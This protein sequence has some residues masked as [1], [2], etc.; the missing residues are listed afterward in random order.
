MFVLKWGLF[1]KE[2]FFSLNLYFKNAFFSKMSF[3]KFLHNFFFFFNN[4]KIKS[5]YIKKKKKFFF[6][7]KTV[8]PIFFFFKKGYF[9]KKFSLTTLEFLL[10]K[11]S[12]EWAKFVKEIFLFLKIMRFFLEPKLSL[13][14]AMNIFSKSFF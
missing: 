8:K 9:Q 6:S 10:K 13:K 1:Q 11:K 3:I 5:F 7:I 4:P 12:F 14:K 2:E